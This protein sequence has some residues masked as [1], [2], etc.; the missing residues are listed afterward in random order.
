MTIIIKGESETYPISEI[1]KIIL[2]LK[3]IS[4]QICELK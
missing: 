2:S 3:F 4:S 1:A